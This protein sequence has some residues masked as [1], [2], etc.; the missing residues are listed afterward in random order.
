MFIIIIEGAIKKREPN[1]DNSQIKNKRF[2]YKL[3]LFVDLVIY[4]DGFF[5]TKNL[6]CI[7]DFIFKMVSRWRFELQT[8]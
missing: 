4:K 3:A 8:L 6:E 5:Y 2:K 7:R 1:I